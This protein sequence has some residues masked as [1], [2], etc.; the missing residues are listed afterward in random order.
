MRL[1]P[2]AVLQR[3]YSVAVAEFVASTL[4]GNEIST[5]GDRQAG[6]GVGVF[7]GRG[8]AVGVGLGVSLGLGVTVGVGLGVS[9]GLGVTVGV[10]LGVSLGLGV[11]VGVGFGVSL[12]LGVTVGVGVATGPQPGIPGIQHFGSL[13]LQTHEDP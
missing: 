11:T 9:L 7:V 12:G 6:V 8:V 13:M 5:F 4:N 2:A 10:G 1:L 3:L